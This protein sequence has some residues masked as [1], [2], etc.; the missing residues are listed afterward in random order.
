MRGRGLWIA[1][2]LGVLLAGCATT[3]PAEL[4][5]A[6]TARC[7]SYGFRKGSDGLAQCLLQID[8]ERSAERSARLNA[9]Y[10]YGPGWYGPA[11]RR[12][13]W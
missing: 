9:P 10:V 5:A 13:W 1:A 3:T 11:F 7:R 6:D 4:R 8:L 12:Y 2:S